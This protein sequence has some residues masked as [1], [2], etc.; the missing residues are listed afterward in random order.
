MA[1][2]LYGNLTFHDRFAGIL[3]QEPDGR[4]AFNYDP[5]YLAAGNPAIR[6][7]LQM[8]DGGWSI[9][10][11]L[12]YDGGGHVT[13]Q[14]ITNSGKNPAAII[15]RNSAGGNRASLLAKVISGGGT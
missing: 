6:D 14:T 13:A 11:Y 5:A 15:P 1:E 3:R 9:A 8:P 7:L 4:F 10:P 12:Q 2:L